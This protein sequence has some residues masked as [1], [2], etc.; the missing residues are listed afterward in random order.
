MVKKGTISSKGQITL[1]KVLREKYHF[2]AGETVVML[3]S[4]DGILIKHPRESL[5]GLLK[6]E[7]DIDKFEKELKKLR[8]EWTT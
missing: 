3:D 7:I 8:K 2:N 6:E 5:R 1:P 4:G